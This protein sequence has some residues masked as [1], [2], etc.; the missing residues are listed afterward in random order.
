MENKKELRE[1]IIEMMVSTHLFNEKFRH[2]GLKADFVPIAGTIEIF[3]NDTLLGVSHDAKSIWVNNKK[4]NL[5][6]WIKAWSKTKFLTC[7]G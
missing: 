2:T 5:I 3:E 1:D 4:E 7:L 6:T